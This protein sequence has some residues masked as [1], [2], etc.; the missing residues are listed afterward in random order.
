MSPS[1]LYIYH[2]QEG[3]TAIMLA[4]RCGHSEL[5]KALLDVGADPHEAVEQVAKTG[6][7]E[8]LQ[9]LSDRGVEFNEAYGVSLFSVLYDRAGS[10]PK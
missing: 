7:F 3:L 6:N 1:S 2:Q 10:A 4:A 9:M 5:F 8:M